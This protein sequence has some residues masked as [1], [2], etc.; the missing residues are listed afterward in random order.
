[1]IPDTCV[2]IIYRMDEEKRIVVSDFNGINDSSF[3]VHNEENN[4]HKMS[5]FAIRFYAWG[6]SVFAEDSFAGTVNGRSDVRERFSWLGRELRKRLV[7]PV[8]LADIIHLT[9]RLLINRLQTARNH[10][11][12]DTAIDNIILHHGALDVSRLSRECFIGSR[13]LERQFHEYIGITPKKLSNL[14]REFKRYHLMN[15]QTARKTA[16]SD[17]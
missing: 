12:I 14:V 2:D 3:Y 17:L 7:E 15:I 13:Q 1:M 16:F 10:E 8:D 5:V 11:L 4:V 6:D 9:E